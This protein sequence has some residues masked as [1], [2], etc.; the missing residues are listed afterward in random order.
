MI[1]N[2]MLFLSMKGEKM[3]RKN[4]ILNWIKDRRDNGE[5]PTLCVFQITVPKLSEDD[6]LEDIE[7]I[8]ILT[9]IFSKYQIGW[10]CVDTVDGSFNLN[11]EWIETKDIPCYIEYCGVYPADWDIEDI[12]TLERMENEGN[13]IIRVLWHKEEKYIPNN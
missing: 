12:I 8:K 2:E 3:E 11:R 5:K 13:I 1:C 9:N 4:M 10:N 7:N 6:N